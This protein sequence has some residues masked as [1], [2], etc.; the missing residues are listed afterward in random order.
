MRNYVQP[1]LHP[2][3]SR[4][5][6]WSDRKPLGTPEGDP[7]NH[8]LRSINLNPR[9]FYIL[10]FVYLN[11]CVVLYIL[12]K[13]SRSKKV[14]NYLIV[15]ICVYDRAG[16]SKIPWHLRCRMTSGQYLIS[17]TR[18]QSRCS[19][20]RVYPLLKHSFAVLLYVIGVILIY[21]LDIYTA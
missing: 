8:C 7:W 9:C 6:C 20:D 3:T 13:E 18:H 12:L 5:S 19:F 10:Y 17:D 11:I 2:T 14:I 21:R 15:C 4:A 16:S 1:V